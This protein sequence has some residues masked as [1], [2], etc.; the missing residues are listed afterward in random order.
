VAQR[1]RGGPITHRSHDRNLALINVFLL[2]INFQLT[3]ILIF[4]VSKL[5]H[6]TDLG[7]LNSMK[8]C[9]VFTSEHIS[10]FLINISFCVGACI[11]IKLALKL[12]SNNELQWH[13]TIY[14]K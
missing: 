3:L 9:M 12:V 4:L 10:F 6:Q 14:Y 7:S 13:V 11:I 5:I 1:K 8:M 2:C